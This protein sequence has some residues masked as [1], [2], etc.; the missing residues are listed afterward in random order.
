MQNPGLA[1]RSTYFNPIIRGMIQGGYK[2]ITMISVD[3]RQARCKS[4]CAYG[5]DTSLFF[6]LPQKAVIIKASLFEAIQRDSSDYQNWWTIGLYAGI[7]LQ[8][9]HNAMVKEV[10]G[11]VPDIPQ[12]VSDEGLNCYHWYWNRQELHFCYRIAGEKA[13]TRLPLEEIVNYLAPMPKKLIPFLDSQFAHFD[14][15]GFLPALFDGAASIYRCNFHY[16][17]LRRKMLSGS[18]KTDYQRW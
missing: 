6:H 11:F 4:P 16:K 14:A 12:L 3:S 2:L 8:K 7:D 18:L 9:L 13:G 10:G 17:E 1:P 5:R 15:S